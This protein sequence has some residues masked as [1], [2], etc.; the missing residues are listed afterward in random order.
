M[1]VGN[2]I[3]QLE[4][5]HHCGDQGQNRAL[6]DFTFQTIAWLCVEQLSQAL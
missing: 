2:G 5:R 6:H 1:D 3:R 4:N